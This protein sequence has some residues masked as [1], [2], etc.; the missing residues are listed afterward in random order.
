MI[1]KIIFQIL[2]SSNHSSYTKKI[3][4]PFPSF[5][6]SIPPSQKSI[7]LKKK[8]KASTISPRKFRNTDRYVSP[9]TKTLEST[10]PKHTLHPPSLINYRN[11]SQKE[12]KEKEHP[13]DL[14][15]LVARQGGV[16]ADRKRI[17]PASWPRKQK[18]TVE[19]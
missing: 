6:I 8:P 19:G 5:P 4:K 3:R 17:G 2:E 12:K 11:E 15:D 13:P 14:V 7:S 1:S 10:K 16:V 18:A 9:P